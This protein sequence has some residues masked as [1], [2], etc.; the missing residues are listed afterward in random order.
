M[1]RPASS[2]WSV[3]LAVWLAAC[4]AVEPDP[5][6]DQDQGESEASEDSSATT[7]E[8]ESLIDHTLWASVEAD[9]DPLADH[10]P[11]EITC[12]VAGWFL[13]NETLEINTNYCNYL[14]IGQPSLVAVEQGR[15]IEL[16][17]YHF[18]LVAPEPAL[19]HLAI[20][21]DGALLWEQ[22]IEIP[23]AAMVYLVEFEAPFS[24]PAGSPL[25]LHLHNHGQ[26]TWAL[27]SLSAEQ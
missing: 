5:G 10:R 4:G 26:N 24:A 8:L 20:L 1:S 15:K 22:E 14:A 2:R 23:G 19:A 16:G 18:N 17:F 12:T 25:I 13:E 7:G 21:L 27:Q 9:D 6:A 3:T 11:D